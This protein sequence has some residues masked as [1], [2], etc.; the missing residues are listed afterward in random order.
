M[1]NKDIFISMIRDYIMKLGNPAELVEML[2]HTE[3]LKTKTNEIT[4]FVMPKLKGTNSHSNISVEEVYDE[5]ILFYKEELPEY[6][7]ILTKA[8]EYNKSFNER[9][10]SV[11]NSEN[12]AIYNEISKF[13]H[14][15]F[16][17][18]ITTAEM[19][20]YSCL[21][22]IIAHNESKDVIKLTHTSKDSTPKAE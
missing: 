13:I 14:N 22:L 19:L 10:S 11:S 1:K 17:S 8:T 6:Q 7:E 5:I 2:D 18:S 9:S 4:D 15:E 20:I 16:E 3:S 21:K 12:D